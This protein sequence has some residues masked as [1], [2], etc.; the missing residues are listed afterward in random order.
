MMFVV[1]CSSVPAA[2][3]IRT[4]IMSASVCIDHLF[5]GD[6]SVLHIIDIQVLNQHSSAN[7]NTVPFVRFVRFGELEKHLL[8]DL[9]VNFKSI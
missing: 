3:M 8:Y 7:R 4:V 2:V 6:L 9:L 5:P 1:F